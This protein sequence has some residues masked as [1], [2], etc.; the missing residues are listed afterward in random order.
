MDKE[1]FSRFLRKMGKKDHVIQELIKSVEEFSDYLEKENFSIGSATT[2]YLQNFAD[3]LEKQSMKNIIRGVALYYRSIGNIEMAKFAAAIREK[4]LSSE[5]RP[6]NLSE[7]RDIDLSILESLH[8]VGITHTSQMIDAGKTPA[9]REKLSSLTG[10]SPDVILKLVKLS[11]L[12]R[13][14]AVKAIRAQLYFQY[15]VDTPEKLA[16]ADAEE[17]RSNLDEFIQNSGF[18]GIAPLPKEMRC[19]IEDARKLP[20]IVE[21]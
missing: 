9:L 10:I 19:T 4:Q 13:L 18:K 20:R 7:F 8:K 2:V 5:R 17:L 14:F 6:L 3:S 21:Y 15:G 11:D 1:E 12:A 16:N